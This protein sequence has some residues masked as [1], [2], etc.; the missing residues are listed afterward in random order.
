MNTLVLCF[1]QTGKTKVI[2]SLLSQAIGA[3]F[4]EIKEI[5]HRTLLE[6]HTLGRL[7]A[8]SRKTSDIRPIQADIADYDTIILGC[9][10]WGGYPVPALYDFI[11][12]YQIEGKR[13][14]GLLTYINYQKNA[15][16]V[17]REEIEAAS[18]VCEQIVA[19]KSGPKTMR[20]VREG[21]IGFEWN[22]TGGLVIKGLDEPA[23]YE[24]EAAPEETAH[25]A[26]K[27]LTPTD[28]APDDI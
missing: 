25:P 17:L 9:P 8:R 5:H 1:S 16:Q 3:D 12:E 26:L 15:G 21:S 6:A 11:R 19:I 10:I 22:E 13:I 18:A 2:C 28:N 4:A 27:A 7:S 24:T 23:V 20:A 14:I